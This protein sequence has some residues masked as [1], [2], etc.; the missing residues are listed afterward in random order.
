MA[1]NLR[2]FIILIIHN[3]QRQCLNFVC[4]W[5]EKNM[6]TNTLLQTIVNISIRMIVTG[7][8]WVAQQL[9]ICLWLTGSR[10]AR[11]ESHIRFPAWSLLLPL[12]MS[13]P[14]SICVSHE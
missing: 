14:L 5:L 9:S 4:P 8:T 7:D 2:R 3:N 10:S 6:H 12:P 1:L 13:L 11:I